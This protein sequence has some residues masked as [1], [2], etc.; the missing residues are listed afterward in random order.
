MAKRITTE[1]LERTICCKVKTTAGRIEV[2][3]YI[4][5]KNNLL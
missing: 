2:V 1:F 4:F 5:R 3:R